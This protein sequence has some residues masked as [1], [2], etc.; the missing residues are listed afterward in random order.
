MFP[1]A[2]DLLEYKTIRF[3]DYEQKTVLEFCRGTGTFYLN[4]QRC[5]LIQDN[6]KTS[7]Q[8]YANIENGCYLVMKCPKCS[9]W[10]EYSGLIKYQYPSKNGT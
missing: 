8:S 3:V 1:M 2:D 10:L 4:C 7:P 9:E 5:G 6:F